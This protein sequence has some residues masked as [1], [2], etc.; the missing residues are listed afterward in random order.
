MATYSRYKV[1]DRSGLKHFGARVSASV[2]TGCTDETHWLRVEEAVTR[3][4]AQ[5]PVCLGPRGTEA[6]SLAGP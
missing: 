5:I 1:L 2:G 6:E 3:D 4:S